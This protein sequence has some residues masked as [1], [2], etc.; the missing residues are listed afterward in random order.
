MMAGSGFETTEKLSSPPCCSISAIATP[1]SIC[2]ATRQNSEWEGKDRTLWSD[3]ERRALWYEIKKFC[4]EE[5][6]NAFDVKDLTS[7]FS[8]ECAAA[9]NVGK[10][11]EEKERNE[12]MIRSQIRHAI[13]N[14]SEK[15]SNKCIQQLSLRAKEMRERITNGEKIP[16]AEQ[17]PDQTS[18]M[19]CP[20]AGAD[21]DN[22]GEEV[23]RVPELDKEGGD[24][25]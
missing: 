2:A 19:E 15:G 12:G 14:Q 5:G 24:S 6:F 1:T 18:S 21:E 7:T 10:G 20:T 4:K 22:D 25:N 16:R 13:R 17:Y 8:T 23:E 9:V 11:S 3:K